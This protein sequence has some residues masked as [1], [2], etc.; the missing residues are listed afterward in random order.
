MKIVLTTWERVQL[1][2]IVGSSWGVTIAQ[3]DLGLRALGVLNLSDEEKAEVGW[4]A[5]GLNQFG[6]NRNC[7]H[8]LEFPDDVWQIVQAFVRA[9]QAWPIDERVKPLWEKVLE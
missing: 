2:V 1:A 4:T 6:W 7:E 9:F 5:A 3:V 8:E